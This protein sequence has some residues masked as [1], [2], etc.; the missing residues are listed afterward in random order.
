MHAAYRLSGEPRARNLSAG[1]V[2]GLWLLGVTGCASE[3]QQLLERSAAAVTYRLPPEQV[4]TATRELLQ[5]QG[6]SIMESTDPDYVRPPWR[7]KFDDTLDVGAVRERQFVM[8]KRLGDGRFVLNAYRLSYTT[9][10]RTA[11]HPISVKNDPGGAREQR[12]VK[13][14]PL[15]NARPVLARDLELEWRILS[16]VSPA[17]AHELES[18][19]DQ[20]LGARSK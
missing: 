12:M 9:I 20:Y 11:P 14:D 15:S 1:V 19:V 18:Q 17:V 10:G 7:V 4:L 13:G 5:E 3:R 16:R 6:Y 2:L 8:V